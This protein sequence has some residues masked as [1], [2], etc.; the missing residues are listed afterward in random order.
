MHVA[1]SCRHV[2][3]RTVGL[4]GLNPSDSSTPGPRHHPASRLFDGK[5]YVTSGNANRALAHVHR[6]PPQG[7]HWDYTLANCGP[8]I[9]KGRNGPTKYLLETLRGRLCVGRNLEAS[10]QLRGILRFRRAI[11]TTSSAKDCLMY[12]D[13]A[14]TLSWSGETKSW[15]KVITRGFPNSSYG[16]HCD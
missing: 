10:S 13:H 1:G 6:K 8:T 14:D 15:S 12:H 7:A 11:Q 3:G 16:G 4:V 2:L 9:S 5:M